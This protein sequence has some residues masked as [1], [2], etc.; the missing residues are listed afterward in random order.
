MSNLDILLELKQRGLHDVPERK[1]FL[2]LHPE[3]VPGDLCEPLPMSR[4]HGLVG[5]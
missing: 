3:V 1:V 2:L 4:F 5:H